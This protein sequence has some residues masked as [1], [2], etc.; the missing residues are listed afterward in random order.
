MT[1]SKVTLLF[2]AALLIAAPANA[3]D[4]R[5]APEWRP[6]WEEI[7][8]EI[9]SVHLRDWNWNWNEDGWHPEPHP[10]ARYSGIRLRQCIADGLDVEMS[11]DWHDRGITREMVAEA[12]AHPET[13]AQRIIILK[14]LQRPPPNLRE[15]LGPAV[16]SQKE[17]HAE[18]MPIKVKLPPVND[19]LIMPPAEFDR[20]Y[21]GNRLLITRVD[22]EGIRASCQG[23]T[24]TGCAYRISEQTCF[25]WIVYDDILNY[26]RYSY[27]VVYRH[28]RAH[29]NGWH[30]PNEWGRD[31]DKR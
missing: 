26:Q 19:L 3:Q 28:E 13:D 5:Y 18:R 29:C 12:P 25:V 6:T 2:V 27:D 20:E 24:L 10:C 8:G 11:R 9:P 4:E 23:K 15:H 1:V 31:T 16:Y 30:H 21:T 22:E 7:L 14:L 17:W